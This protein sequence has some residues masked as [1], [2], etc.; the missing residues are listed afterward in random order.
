MFDPAGPAPETGQQDERGP[1]DLREK[2]QRGAQGGAV[3]LG[4]VHVQDA[5]VVGQPVGDG[6]ER[7][8]GI[9]ERPA[10]QPEDAQ[11]VFQDPRLV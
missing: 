5:D 2:A 6:L 7:V 8:R 3:H 10:V 9:A 4:H 1:A 11:L